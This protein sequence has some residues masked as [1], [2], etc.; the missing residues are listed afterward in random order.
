M[1]PW[2]AYVLGVVTAIAGLAILWFLFRLLSPWAMAQAGGTPI[3]LVEILGMR[4]RGSD[5][6]LIVSALNV[7]RRVGETASPSEVEV[8]YLGLPADQRK[9]DAL[10][11]AL[12]PEVVA[13]LEADARAA[14][15]GG[16]A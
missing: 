8:T 9:L 10:L 1:E 4:L 7:L 16:A 2:V 6:V 14:S 11:R 13:R 3:S 5:P 15:G 12:R